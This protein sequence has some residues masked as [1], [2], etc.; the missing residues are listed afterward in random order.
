MNEHRSK[1][2]KEKQEKLREISLNGLDEILN[3]KFKEQKT[4]YESVHEYIGIKDG[5]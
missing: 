2:V 3:V 4:M 5:F 1:C